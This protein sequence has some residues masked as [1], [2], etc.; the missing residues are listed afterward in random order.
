MLLSKLQIIFGFP[1]S[2]HSCPFSTLGFNPGCHSAFSYHKSAVSTNMWQCLHLSLSFMVRTL[3]CPRLNLNIVNTLLRDCR[4]HERWGADSLHRRS[5]VWWT[6][7]FRSWT[8]SLYLV[9]SFTPPPAPTCLS[10]LLSNPIK[11]SRMGFSLHDHPLRGTSFC[12]QANLVL[13]GF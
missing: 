1:R 2:F 8:P 9:A 5:S 3:T 6:G 7:S 11:L 4:F 12:L 13:A 10:P